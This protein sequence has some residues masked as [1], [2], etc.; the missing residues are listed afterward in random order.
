MTSVEDDDV[1]ED[2]KACCCAML[3]YCLLPDPEESSEN[4]HQ[5]S[6]ID[7]EPHLNVDPSAPPSMSG[8]HQDWCQRSSANNHE[9]PPSYE[10]LFGESEK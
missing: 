5:S 10:S 9:A 6:I 1:I 7:S 4:L 2:C 3:I 8:E